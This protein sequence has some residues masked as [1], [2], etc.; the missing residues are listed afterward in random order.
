MI[1]VC[2]YTIHSH[3]FLSIHGKSNSVFGLNKH[4]QPKKEFVSGEN[5]AHEISLV[6]GVRGW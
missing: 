2:M 3:I 6:C 5:M 1:P 4:L